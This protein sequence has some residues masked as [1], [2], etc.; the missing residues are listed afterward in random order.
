MFFPIGHA[1]HSLSIT[2]QEMANRTRQFASMHDVKTDISKFNGV[3]S[4]SGD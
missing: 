1:S 4:M 3:K 2:L